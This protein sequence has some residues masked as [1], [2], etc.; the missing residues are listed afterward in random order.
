[1]EKIPHIFTIPSEH[2]SVTIIKNVKTGS[3]KLYLVLK[4]KFHDA[5][6]KILDAEE[7]LC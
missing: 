3:M 4:E 6:E 1:M 7:K 5:V 2:V